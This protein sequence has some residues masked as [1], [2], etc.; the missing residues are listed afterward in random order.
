MDYWCQQRA[1][2]N[3]PCYCTFQTPIKIFIEGGKGGFQLHFTMNFCIKSHITK[4]F[5]NQSHV[6]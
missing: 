1:I 4:N 2:K 3:Q 5:F 6:L